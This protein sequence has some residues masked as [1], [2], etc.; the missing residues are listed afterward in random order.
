M[1][2]MPSKSVASYLSAHRIAAICIT[3]V[4]KISVA[5][6]ASLSRVGPVAGIW[7]VKD[8]AAAEQILIAV[9]EVQPASIESATR[10][11]LA[12]AGRLGTVLSEHAVVLARARAATSKLDAKLDQA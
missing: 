9:G 4:G 3:S 7:W 6:P 11:V 8:R 5:T 10:E 1:I 12:A 2:E